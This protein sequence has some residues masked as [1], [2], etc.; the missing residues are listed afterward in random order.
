MAQN[1]KIDWS[2]EIVV[3]TSTSPSN[4]TIPQEP[5]ATF[6]TVKQGSW[7]IMGVAGTPIY[8]TVGSSAATSSNALHP[9]GRDDE[10]KWIDPNT[11]FQALA[12]TGTGQLWFVRCYL[13]AI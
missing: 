2:T 5:M 9:I 8:L 6:P 1:F 13:M 12:A 11:K 7:W 10:P 4:L 3:A